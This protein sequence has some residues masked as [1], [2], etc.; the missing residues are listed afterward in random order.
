MQ[1]TL[2]YVWMF[3]LMLFACWYVPV[4]FVNVFTC[5]D[6]WLGNEVLT[7][8]FWYAQIYF[9][10]TWEGSFTHSLLATLPHVFKWRYMPFITN[11][12]TFVGLIM[13]TWLFVKTYCREVWHSCLIY[14]VVAVCFY[15]TT[16]T[17]G[18]E[19]RFWVCANASYVSGVSILLCFLSLYHR[20]RWDTKVN[21]GLLWLFQFLLCG[22]KLTYLICLYVCMV[23]H[24][25]VFQSFS[26]KRVAL[27]YMPLVLF[28]L[29]N[30][31]APGNY[32]RLNENVAHADRS[33]FI[34]ILFYRLKKIVPMFFWAFML[35]PCFLK[36]HEKQSKTS[37]ILLIFL[38]AIVYFLLESLCMYICFRDPGP[39]RTYILSEVALLICGVMVRDE[40]LFRF[41]VALKDLSCFYLIMGIAVNVLQIGFIQQVPKTITYS[42]KQEDRNKKMLAVKEKSKIEISELPPSYLLLS[43]YA[44]DETWLRNVYLPYFRLK[45]CDVKVVKA[46][47]ATTASGR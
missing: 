1:R 45:D 10:Q 19:V 8:G 24:D 41:N 38:G 28:S 2:T 47:M 17:C 33:S 29:L 42:R 18:A 44:N 30:I 34:E 31:L 26:K 23:T 25:I 37:R 7:K 4:S 12:V 20:D 15:Y 9:Y 35:P 46:E 6:F 21:L 3:A 5:D 22:H 14:A 40:M 13:A 43:Y 32:I 36:G 16:T 39:Q 27:L 11:M